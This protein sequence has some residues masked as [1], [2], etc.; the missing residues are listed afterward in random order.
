MGSR[1]KY[2]PLWMHEATR[3]VFPQD[4]TCTKNSERCYWAAHHMTRKLPSKIWDFRPFYQ[5]EARPKNGSHKKGTKE[6]VFLILF[7]HES[8][9]IGL[10]LD[11]K[12]RMLLLSLRN[13][14][15]KIGTFRSTACSWIDSRSHGAHQTFTGRVCSVAGS[16]NDVGNVRKCQTALWECHDAPQVPGHPSEEQ[17]DLCHDKLDLVWLVACKLT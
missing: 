16:L 7:G 17:A 12:S 15:S 2:F 14:W 13:I 5:I 8:W 3:S 9:V 10:D 1:I 6:G 4:N 11:R